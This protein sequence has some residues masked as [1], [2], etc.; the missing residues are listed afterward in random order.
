MTSLVERLNRNTTYSIDEEWK[1]RRE[2]AAEILGLR[3]E[4]AERDL[5]VHQMLENQRNIEAMLT[6]IYHN[7]RKVT[8]AE[9][10]AGTA[11]GTEL[12]EE[13]AGTPENVV[14]LPFL[15]VG[16]DD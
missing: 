12:S 2:A 11:E 5:V 3:A 7:L 9:H 16:D 10:P 15:G 13:S 14:Y 4:L 8:G 1:L 6:T